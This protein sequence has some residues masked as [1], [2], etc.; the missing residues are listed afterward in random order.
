MPVII[1]E[2]EPA[3]AFALE[4]TQVPPAVTSPKVVVKPAQTANVPVI[5]AG[6]GLMVTGVVIMQPV[7]IL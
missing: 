5:T 6:K 1:P 7:A 4:L 3:L 2:A